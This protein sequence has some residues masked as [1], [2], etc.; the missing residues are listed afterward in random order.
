MPADPLRP[1]PAGRL[2]VVVLNFNGL[3][4]TLDCLAS[5]REQTLRTIDILVVDNASRGEEAAR[6]AAAFPEVEVIALPV[7][8]GWAGGNNL[9]LRLALERGHGHVCLLNNDT[10]LDADALERLLEASARME[11]R[12]M[13]QPAVRYHDAPDTWQLRPEPGAEHGEACL[14]E[15]DFAYG[16]CLLL[17]A[18]LLRQVGLLDERFFLQLEETDYYMR[19]KALGHRSVCALRACITH[20]E[21]ASFGGRVTEAK[22]YYQVRNS[23]LLAEKHTPTPRGFLHAIRATTWSLYHKVSDTDPR[24]RGWGS[25]LRWLL[26][27]QPLARAARQGAGDYVRRR[28]GARVTR[29]G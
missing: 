18:G 1:G 19:A 7:N 25:F 28:F 22:T 5:L 2:L 23:L 14:A 12:A 17:P 8:Q 29:P 3:Q 9:G 21:S 16:V 6:I 20:R 11:G 13:I 24:V 10:T 27:G 15:L 26:S 4:D